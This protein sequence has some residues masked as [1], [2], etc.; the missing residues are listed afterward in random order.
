[1][2]GR[3]RVAQLLEYARING[4][5]GII[6]TLDWTFSH[7][8]DRG[9]PA[10]PQE[11]DVKTLLQFVPEALTRPR[12]LRDFIRAGGPPALTAPNMATPG[13]PAPGF[14]AAQVAHVVPRLLA[15][16]TSVGTR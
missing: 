3:D 7:R 10:I 12:W 2:G 16:A 11:Y 8:R 9:S 1:M 13:A 5:R 14:F 4:A 15:E 6:L